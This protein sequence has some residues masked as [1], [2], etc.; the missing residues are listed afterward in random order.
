MAG[1]ELQTTRSCSKVVVLELVKTLLQVRGSF[2]IVCNAPA[3]SLAELASGDK[4]AEEAL[5]QT[6]KA[7]EIENQREQLRRSKD[8][9]TRSANAHPENLICIQRRMRKRNQSPAHHANSYR[10]E[11][12]FSHLQPSGFT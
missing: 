5:E 6:L 2:I 8:A 3:S 12:H 7:A 11:A 9:Q 1:E 4:A 10:F